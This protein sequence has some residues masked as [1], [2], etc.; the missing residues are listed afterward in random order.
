M[1]DVEG[2]VLVGQARLGFRRAGRQPAALLWLHGGYLSSR[3]W[4][5]PWAALKSRGLSMLAMDLRGHGRSSTLGDQDR[6]TTMA[7]DVARALD[8]LGVEQVVVCGHSLGGM[9]AQ[10]LAWDEP[11]RVRGLILVDTTFSVHDSPLEAAQTTVA[12]AAFTLLSVSRVIE[13]TARE[14][15]VYRPD[16][17]SHVRHEMA[18][19][20]HDR[21]L[22]KRIWRAVLDF[23]LSDR[24]E[25]IT[26]PT[27]ILASAT[28]P[29][30]CRQG[31]QMAER[32]PLAT[33]QLIE[34]A[35]HMIHW[36]QPERFTALVLAF[37]ARW[38]DLTAPQT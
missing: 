4:D 34:R 37:T 30:T 14:L 13:L 2:L 31:H 23:D 38:P 24:L 7:Q 11:A 12:R 9:I 36:D 22:Y 29:N 21:T 25:Q 32:M 16:V 28:N 35:G 1:S 26:C 20:A 8:A 27:L 5:E 10:Q 17:A 15:S 19:Y 18:R 3:T 33:L 6:V